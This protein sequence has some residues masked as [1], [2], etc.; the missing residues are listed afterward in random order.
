MYSLANLVASR[1]ANASLPSTLVLAIPNEIALGITPSEMYCSEVGVEIA[2]LLLR[3]KNRVWHLKV[4]AKLS[5]VGKSPSLAAPS[6][7]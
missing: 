5:A 7:R 1:Q 6:P 3:S 2:Y 4:A